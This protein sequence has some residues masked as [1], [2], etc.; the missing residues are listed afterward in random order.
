M[1]IEK[2]QKIVI[3][4]VFLLVI[5][6]VLFLLKD[7]DVTGV[8]KHDVLNR[9]VTVEKLEKDLGSPV[10]NTMYVMGKDA[11]V[12]VAID[13]E[14]IKKYNLKDYQK[15]QKKYVQNLRSEFKRRFHYDVERKKKKNT[16]TYTITS[17]YYGLYSSDLSR[18]INTKIDEKKLDTS[19]EDE[20]TVVELYKIKVDA[21]E[22]LDKNLDIYKNK[23]KETVKVNIL[24]EKGKKTS[25]NELFSL[26]C[27]AN[28]LTYSNVNF[29]DGKMKEEQNKRI[30]EYK[31]MLK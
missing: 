6:F 8:I 13:Q 20:K 17:I 5:C 10:V 2:N 14:L 12:A 16:Y 9:K 26:F 28:G 7:K 29:S 31:K 27:N 19:K 1:K 25:Q 24:Y 3:I 15:R 4:S 11:Y 18:L 23:N 22:A 21:M 30:E